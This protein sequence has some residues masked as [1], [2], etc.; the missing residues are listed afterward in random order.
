MVTQ[1]IIDELYNYG[2]FE[3][4]YSSSDC[5]YSILSSRTEHRHKLSQF[6]VG[7]SIRRRSKLPIDGRLSEILERMLRTAALLEQRSDGFVLASSQKYPGYLEGNLKD[8]K[9]FVP[10]H[11]VEIF[12]PPQILSEMHAL[13]Q[14]IKLS[15]DGVICLSG[16]SV[17]RGVLRVVGDIDFCEYVFDKPSKV[18][19]LIERLAIRLDKIWLV[20]IYIP[21]SR[22]DSYHPPWHGRCPAR[23]TNMFS[24]GPAATQAPVLMFE[25]IVNDPSL[26]IIPV[27]N[28][29]LPV[30]KNDP[31]AGHGQTTFVFQ[32]AVFAAEDFPPRLLVS[33]TELADYVIWLRDELRV[34][35]NRREIELRDSVKRLKRALSL[36]RII[37]LDELAREALSVLSDARIEGYVR[38]N[39]ESKVHKLTQGL[40]PDHADTII[41]LEK[42]NEPTGSQSRF[43]RGELSKLEAMAREVV[44]KIATAYDAIGDQLVRIVQ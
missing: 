15:D 44:D 9:V 11:L 25:Y 37:Y 10:W 4:H 41:E 29:T 26:G 3:T 19:S 30:D 17:F 5:G 14:R 31:A 43:S 32:E 40:E 36:A 7:L 13:S 22:R 12:A 35:A 21:S 24:K 28:R 27:T 23:L 2:T 16:S 6:T 39:T 18:P 20:R 42:I 34:P 1:L 33:P 38:Q 8:S